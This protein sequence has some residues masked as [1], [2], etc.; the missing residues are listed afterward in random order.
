MNN[1]DI[2]CLVNMNKTTQRGEFINEKNIRL[3]NE[4]TFIKPNNYIDEDKFKNI[5][6]FVNLSNVNQKYFK[7]KYQNYFTDN[8]N[9]NKKKQE[10]K[11][12]ANKK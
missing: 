4:T 8:V 1:P 3:R 7:N 10:S 12:K 11:I 9:K 6:L 2:K 5:S